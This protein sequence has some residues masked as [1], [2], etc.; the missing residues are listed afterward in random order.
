[1]CT[2]KPLSLLPQS[3]DGYLPT[4]SWKY[5]S[6]WCHIIQISVGPFIKKIIIRYHLVIVLV[7]AGWNGVSSALCQQSLL[8]SLQIRWKSL[9]GLHFTKKK[10]KKTT[11]KIQLTWR[12]ASSS[13]KFSARIWS[14]IGMHDVLKGN[15]SY[16]WYS[17]LVKRKSAL[18]PFHP[19][20]YLVLHLFRK[21]LTIFVD[22]LNLRRPLKCCGKKAVKQKQWYPEL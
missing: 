10:K 12:T 6:E 9:S 4:H 13:F 11:T 15:S 17:I 2:R 20:G 18:G 16:C 8:D 22:Q 21:W 19:K 7:W 14:A 3:P 5:Y 1:M